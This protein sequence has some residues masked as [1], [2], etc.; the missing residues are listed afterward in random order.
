MVKIGEKLKTLRTE[1][2]LTQKDL[3]EKLNVSAQAVSRWENDEVEPSLETLGQLASIFSVSVDE[4][5]GK[6]PP[7]SPA[8]APEPAATPEPEVRYVE[9]P[10][11]PVLAVCEVCNKPMYEAND[12]CRETVTHGRS[13]E[14]RVLCR[15]CHEKET[16]SKLR[17]E[18]YDLQTH[19]KR[20]WIWSPLAAIALLILSIIVSVSGEGFTPSILIGGIIVS[21]LLLTFLV[22]VFLDNTFV[23][24]MWEDVA[25]WG[26]VQM[27]GIIFSLDID[28]II[29]LI[30]VRVLLSILSF[31]LAVGAAILATA[32]GL[33]LGIFA[34]PFAISIHRRTVRDTYTKIKTSEHTLERLTGKAGA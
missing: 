25:S 6:E 7:A 22:C 12:I 8:A 3:A 2:H 9:T 20:A 1:Q 16:L 13:T 32:L 4:L 15:V 11:K 17:G 26:F 5:F 31:L 29:F 19:W 14:K 10:A 21:V 28:G 27:P 24:E 33:I 30:V 23:G 34:F 18:S